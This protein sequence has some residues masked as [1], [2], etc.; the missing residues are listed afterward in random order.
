M[1]IF[2]FVLILIAVVILSNL[3]NHF[4]PMLSVPIVQVILGVIFSLIFIPLDTGFILEPEVFFVLFIA[5]LIFN[6][7]MTANKKTLNEMRNPILLAAVGLVFVTVFIVGFFTHW[8]IPSIPLAAAFALAAALGPTDVVAVEAM[9]KR[10]RF[11]RKIISILSG[12]SIINDA[13]GIVCFQ[14]AIIAAATGSINLMHGLGFFLMLSVGGLVVGV[15]LT[16]VKYMLVRWLRS[17]YIE[18]ITLHISIGIITP[19]IIYMAAEW[20]GVSGILAVFSS[21]MVHSLYRDK[22]NPETINLEK[23]QKNI[24]D[25]LAFH[26][27][28]LVFVILGTQLPR[29]LRLYSHGTYNT[30][31]LEIAGSVAVITLAVFVIR[32]IWWVITV[33]RKTYDDP[34]NP[35]T[36]TKSGLIFS[37]AGARGEVPLAIVL[38]IPLLL[39]D[40]RVFPERELII[41]V[42]S[43]VII[44]SLL[45]T[46]FILPLLVESRDDTKQKVQENI[47]RIE[48]LKTVTAFLKRTETA[49]NIAA[50]EIV[51]R[52]YFARISQHLNEGRRHR[53][54]HNLRSD[55]L[56]WEKDVV[57]RMA[58][59]EQISKAA[60]EHYIE[61]VDM[62]LEKKSRER[63]IL[64][65][66]VSMAQHFI[67]FFTWKEPKHPDANIMQSRASLS[68][69]NM[70]NESEQES[71]I[72]IA[73]KSFHM[74]RSLIRHMAADGR[75]SE[76]TAKEMQANITMLEAQL[77]AE[78]IE[79]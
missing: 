34:E 7:T 30:S 14:F 4:L 3:I 29:I 38:S 35:I 32:F 20:A 64:G 48:I 69:L 60:A 61:T 63:N 57:L 54:R 46:N 31:P 53:V 12:E 56:F 71:V 9:E 47:A 52:N 19:F 49:E 36:K 66:L 6:S 17:L 43:C 22:F 65:L 40:G 15:A 42:V 76:K 50:T 16:F 2:N 67:Y 72:D 78:E 68:E 23:A 70:L 28:G 79:D 59:N 62:M 73:E 25:L 41:L 24:W 75:I 5:P 77:A 33:R 10:V 74:E 26:L 51:R 13:T 8:L 58:E 21:G 55:I 1:S 39:P 37:M 11:P 45:I 18:S 44:L 27:D